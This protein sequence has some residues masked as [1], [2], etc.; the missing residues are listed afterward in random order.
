MCQA[1]LEIHSCTC[2][3]SKIEKRCPY[4]KSYRCRDALRHPHL[5]T[6][7]YPCERHPT[8][9]EI[10]PAFRS[11]VTI[12]RRTGGPYTELR[13][14]CSDKSNDT[15]VP[16]TARTI[17]TERFPPF[18]RRF[19]TGENTNNLVNWSLPFHPLPTDT[20]NRSS[21]Y[22]HSIPRPLPFRNSSPSSTTPTRTT[23]TSRPLFDPGT[24]ITKPPPQ[25]PSPRSPRCISPRTIQPPR[26]RFV[27][28]PRRAMSERARDQRLYEEHKQRETER[29]RT[30]FPQYELRNGVSSSFPVPTPKRSNSNSNLNLQSRT[31]RGRGQGRTKTSGSRTQICA[32]M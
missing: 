5:Q 27:P 24:H 17:T 10:H 1:I 9:E 12:C 19:G 22:G 2:I 13:D 4:S 28:S 14:R 3:G 26:P 11:G 20:P 6:L 18:G 16:P 29:A 25:L 32:V 21:S 23:I 8:I 7:N 15:D 30:Q 31:A